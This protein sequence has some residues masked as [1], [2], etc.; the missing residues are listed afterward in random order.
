MCSIGYRSTFRD[1][2]NR[3]SGFADPYIA[4]SIRGDCVR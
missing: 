4:N 3:V 2:Q 1:A